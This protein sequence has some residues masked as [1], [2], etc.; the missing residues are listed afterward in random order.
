MDMQ[1]RRVLGKAPYLENRY[2][3]LE[4]KKTGALFSVGP[5]WTQYKLTIKEVK[6]G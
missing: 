4:K 2:T 3:A 5:I 6:R 1:Q